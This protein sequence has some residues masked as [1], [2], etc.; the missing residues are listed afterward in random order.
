M[1]YCNTTPYKNFYSKHDFHTRFSFTLE[2]WLEELTP[3]EIGF[4]AHCATLFNEAPGELFDMLVDRKKRRLPL[5]K[6]ERM[7]LKKQQLAEQQQLVLAFFQQVDLATFMYDLTRLPH[8]FSYEVDNNSDHYVIG[9][10]T[11]EETAPLHIK[12]LQDYTVTYYTEELAIPLSIHSI[13]YFV[14]ANEHLHDL[15][16]GRQKHATSADALY[17][18]SYYESLIGQ[19]YELFYINFPYNC[20]TSFYLA[21]ISFNKA[22][23][24]LTEQ[25]E[26]G[27]L[28]ALERQYIDVLNHCYADYQR[29]QQEKVQVKEQMQLKKVVELQQKYD[30]LKG[31]F[32]KQVAANQQLKVEQKQAPIQKKTDY[33]LQNQHSDEKKVLQQTIQALEHKVTEL[34]NQLEKAESSKQ[35][36]LQQLRH[37]NSQLQKQIVQIRRSAVPAGEI[38]FE[39]WLKKGKLFLQ[40][41]SS[42]DEVALQNFIELAQDTLAERKAS[43]PKIALASNKIGYCIVNADGHFIRLADG[44]TEA[45]HNI[46]DHIYLSD[47]EFIEVTKDFE[48]ARALNSFFRQSVEDGQIAHFAQIEQVHQDFVAKFDGKSIRYR[49]EKNFNPRHGQIISLNSEQELVRYYTSK[50]VTLDDLIASIKLK[51]HAPYFIELVLKNGYAMRNILTNEQTFIALDKPLSKGCFVVLKDEQSLLYTDYTGLQYKRSNFYKKKTLASISDIH[52]DVFV[53]KANQEYVMLTNVLNDYTPELGDMI[54]IDEEHA[55]ISVIEEQEH[56]VTA[57]LEQRLKNHPTMKV[58]RQTP[59]KPMLINQKLVIIGNV[60]LS[61]R[62]KIHFAQFGF[63]TETVD[64]FGSFEKIRMACA[65]AD[66]IIYSTAFT[67]HKNSGKVKTDI[68]QYVILCDS[69]SPHVISRKLEAQIS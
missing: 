39:E 60:R 25:P 15:N 67:S 68:T 52:D 17:A 41:L 26:V 9:E 47:D 24:F 33:T 28:A 63:E 51:Q 50:Y 12:N 53:L 49:T 56:D 64:G 21:L 23:R 22:F 8:I 44:T 59:K 36:E 42:S 13:I 54:W 55:M 4:L 40:Q 62:Y 46:P 11:G 38:S 2:D 34:S 48:F 61:E 30:K 18:S 7:K 10:R 20:S 58:L 31:N 1:L 65:K 16:P 6:Y 32:D 19:H 57:T 66:V 27:E 14:L 35:T 29:L 45:I 5:I 43:R 3:T 69:T 37:E